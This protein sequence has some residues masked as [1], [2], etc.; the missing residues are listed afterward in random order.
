M[1]VAMLGDSFKGLLKIKERQRL[2]AHTEFT[3]AIRD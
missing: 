2:Q 1:V 3:L